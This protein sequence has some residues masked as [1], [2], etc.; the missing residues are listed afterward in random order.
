MAGQMRF[1]GREDEEE[2]CVNWTPGGCSGTKDTSQEIALSKRENFHT[3][4]LSPNLEYHNDTYIATLTKLTYE[5]EKT[6]KSKKEEKGVKIQNWLSSYQ[7]TV[8]NWT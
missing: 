3:P 6:E 5:L 4:K 2:M 7:Q 8:L 1:Y